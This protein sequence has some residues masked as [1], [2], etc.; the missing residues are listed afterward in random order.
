[1]QPNLPVPEQKALLRQAL[2]QQR[3]EYPPQAQAAQNEA[4]NRRLCQ[5][6]QFREAEMVLGYY[7]IGSAARGF[8]PDIRPALLEA[9]ALGKRVALPR[10]TPD[11]PGNMAFYFVDSLDD[12]RPGS[13]GVPEP[14]PERHEPLPRPAAGLCLVPALAF[15]GEG[16]RLGYGKGYYDRFLSRFTGSSLGFC[17]QDFLLAQLPRG[18]FDLP[19]DFVLTPHT[20]LCIK[21]RK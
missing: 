21:E 19:V 3:R 8:E 11:E 20:I 16:Y 7:P 10:C 12:L 2:L 14:D 18:F 9:L 1:M 6:R 13:F 17:F 5:L 15:D 4:L